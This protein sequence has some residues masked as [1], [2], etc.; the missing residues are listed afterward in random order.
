MFGSRY[1]W[2]RRWLP[3]TYER[4]GVT[5][6]APS[7]YPT[8][9]EQDGDST[10][11]I[12]G[13]NL[14]SDRQMQARIPTLVQ[15]AP[16][17]DL[18]CG[19]LSEIRE[20][21]GGETMTKT[22][23]TQTATTAPT[24]M[25]VEPNFSTNDTHGD[26]YILDGTSAEVTIGTTEPIISEEYTSHT[27]QV[28]TGTHYE[29]TR[30][31]ITENAHQIKTIIADTFNEDHTPALPAKIDHWTLDHNQF[32]NLKLRRSGGVGDPVTYMV[33][34]GPKLFQIVSTETYDNYPQTIT[35][36]D[37][38]EVSR[39]AL[40]PEE[41]SD[42][43]TTV[44]PGTYTDENIG[45]SSSGGSS[46]SIDPTGIHSFYI[47]KNLE[48]KNLEVPATSNTQSWNAGTT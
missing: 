34:E 20:S 18:L 5:Y 17:R 4:N 35:T 15:S 41:F 47:F 22:T 48:N 32:F 38:E 6:W 16:E 30:T 45:P 1:K 21:S 37:W 26:F 43:S 23:I 44:V 28:R 11:Y 46:Y 9:Y 40:G 29:R 42:E 12:M 36:S 24:S 14:P 13:W 25:L 7:F 33:M 19:L 8:V 2:W 31:V 39:Q 3:K 27:R 10:R